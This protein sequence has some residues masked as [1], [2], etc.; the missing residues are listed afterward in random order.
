MGKIF[1][2]IRFK[3]VSVIL[4]V[5]AA[6]ISVSLAFIVANTKENLL[7]SVRRNLS[8]NNQ[9]L[10]TVIRNLMLAGE[11]PIAVQTLQGLKSLEEFEELAIY[12]ADGTTAFNDYATI[13]FVNRFQDDI[14]FDQTERT[15]RLILE[16]PN[17]RSVLETNTP[18]QNELAAERKMEYFFPILNYA[19]C[20]TCHGPS[21][22][23]RGVAYYKVSTANSYDRINAAGGFL[24]SFLAVM[25]FAI[26]VLLILL[27]QRIVVH[28]ILAI[29]STVAE[30]G[31][32]NLDVS[33]RLGT[34]D[35]LGRLALKI[36]E[37]IEGLKS[38]NRLLI[39]NKTIEARNQENRKYLDNIGQG[40]LLIGADFRIREQYSAFLIRLFGRA[41]PA[42]KG[43][44]DFIYPDPAART[45]REELETFL[46]LVFRNTLTEMDMIQAANPLRDKVL[47]VRDEAGGERRIVVDVGFAR[48]MDGDEVES[49]MAIFEDRT[50]IENAREELEA[51]RERRN[52]ELE[53]IAAILNAG[54]ASFTEFTEEAVEAL[55]A[56]K[57]DYGA[58]GDGKVVASLFRSFH[59]LKGS[60]RYLELQSF[61]RRAHALEDE[62]AAIRDGADPATRMRELEAAAARL[63]EEVENVRS[64]NE[65]FR[66]FAPA[67][68]ER[69]SAARTDE[70]LS[71]IKAMALGMAQ[72]LGKRIRVELRN[73]IGVLPRLSELRN[74]LLHMVRNALDHGLEEGIERLSAGKE[75]EG[76]LSIR[77]YSPSPG[78]IAVEVEDD[79]R[80]I[81]FEA[82]RQK[83]VQRGLLA[84]GEAADSDRLARIIFRPGFSSRDAVTGTSGR[85]VGLDAVA[86][87]VKTVGGRISVWTKKNAGARFTIRF[88]AREA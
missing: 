78:E 55:E 49:V 7:G 72:E 25:G 33:I 77:L 57:R 10:T 71:R 44:S 67:A 50:Q 82:V 62:L 26:A 68:S 24:A 28:P 13:E 43:F 18:R 23:I 84:D 80:G 64:I 32:G 54:P 34:K 58:L 88:P 46:S 76:R 83:A 87:A 53:E 86:E 2:S 30:V 11:A 20:R 31:A 47:L 48:I 5:L 73:E 40:L 4:L 75:E 69:G 35:E 36:N 45:E 15:E 3:I 60:A 51:Q 59:S 8:V 16:N 17:F 12:R 19:Q 61:E 14:F 79:G 1:G 27:M 85:G 29:G 37:M 38:R 52:S 81:D 22:F 70:V 63:A 6:S 74:P 65:R 42:G 21:P 56:L 66:A 9:I 41:E 39:E